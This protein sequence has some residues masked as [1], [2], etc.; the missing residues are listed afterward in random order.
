MK[1]KTMAKKQNSGQKPQQHLLLKVMVASAILLVVLFGVAIFIDM[2]W[3]TLTPG[4]QQW[5]AGFQQGG[6]DSLRHQLMDSAQ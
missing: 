2:R 5:V 6:L 1:G 4:E 3:D